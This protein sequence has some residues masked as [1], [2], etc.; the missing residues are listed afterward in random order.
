MTVF[1]LLHTIY[2]HTHTHT[3]TRTGE[4]TET[5]GEE[6]HT[7]NEKVRVKLTIINIKKY[8]EKQ[9]VLTYSDKSYHEKSPNS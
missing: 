4:L 8:V 9:K 2:I 3:H 6:K 7:N 1:P 5:V